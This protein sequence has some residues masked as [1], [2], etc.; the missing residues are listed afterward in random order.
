[1]A[2]VLSMKFHQLSLGVAVR[3]FQLAAGRHPGEF[4][5]VYSSSSTIRTF[6]FKEQMGYG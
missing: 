2:A 6:Y 5:S 3:V 4:N 1:M